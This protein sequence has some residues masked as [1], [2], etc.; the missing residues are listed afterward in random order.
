MFKRSVFVA[1]TVI[2]TF[3]LYGCST[4]MDS[5]HG[6]NSDIQNTA[7]APIQSQ[8]Q[9]P[10]SQYID[11]IKTSIGGS[12]VSNVKVHYVRA[13]DSAHSI[14]LFTFEQ[15]GQTLFSEACLTKA[16]GKWGIDYAADAEP[17]TNSMPVYNMSL[18]ASFGKQSEFLMFGGIIHD[19]AVASVALVKPNGEVYRK[20]HIIHAG[21]IRMYAYG[22]LVSVGKS[23]QW[24][25]QAYDHYGSVISPSKT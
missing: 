22:Q 12:P 21:D 3:F 2:I 24:T 4:Q 19:P 14:C 11:A 7:V 15:D 8:I 13:L 1:G 10:S 17:I 6:N 16:N 5:N 20:L 23:T 25:L 18:S 9:A